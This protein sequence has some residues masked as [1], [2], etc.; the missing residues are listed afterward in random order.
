MT[1]AVSYLSPEFLASH[2]VSMTKPLRDWLSRASYLSKTRTC[3][4]DRR[5]Y[6]RWAIGVVEDALRAPGGI[7]GKDWAHVSPVMPASAE[8]REP[9][10]L[11]NS[12]DRD[13]CGRS[14]ELSSVDHRAVLFTES[15]RRAPTELRSFVVQAFNIIDTEVSAGRRSYDTLTFMEMIQAAQQLQRVYR[16]QAV[17]T[18]QHLCKQPSIPPARPVVGLKPTEVVHGHQWG[19]KLPRAPQ[20]EEKPHK[21]RRI[22]PNQQREGSSVVSSSEEATH[23]RLFFRDLVSC[24]SMLP[25]TQA[26][27]GKSQEMER[28]YSRYEPTAEDIRPREVLEKAFVF[29]FS[30]AKV[31]E[32]QEGTLASLRYLNEQLKGIRQ[33]L[34]VQNILDEFAVEVYERHALICLELGDIGEFNQC[35]SSLKKLY[36]G[37]TDTTRQ[38][39]SDFFCY[40]LAYLCLGGQYDAL[41]T[42]LIT[43]TNTNA[44]G[45]KAPKHATQRVKKSDVR[46]T[47]KLCTAC[48][49][50]DCF[51]ICRSLMVLPRGM[52]LL[53]K[54]YLQKCRLKWL[55]ELLLC[56]RGMVSI[57]F[58]MACLGFTPVMEPEHGGKE[59]KGIFWLDGSCVEAEEAVKKFFEMIKFSVPERFSFKEDI[60]RDMAK[61]HHEQGGERRMDEKITLVDA[62]ALFKC[63]DEYIAYLG[64]RRDARLHNAE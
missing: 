14:V 23:T 3:E 10:F 5:R 56:L 28:M 64:T 45:T 58:I 44:K 42:E 22:E 2:G 63:V 6:E 36:E 48:E 30:K 16:E 25:S 51:T 24:N 59:E 4:A 19:V 39:M 26:F 11:Q 49:D 7:E 34:R 52:H 17:N 8:D 37:L 33:D 27:V 50:G 20:E 47:L 31:K 1:K 41:A 38:S 29:V 32:M 53:V 60:D 61:H 21:A 43:Y 57:R 54:I 46:W 35:Q 9:A 62:A 18:Q 40:R 15:M 55:R 13:Q 12:N